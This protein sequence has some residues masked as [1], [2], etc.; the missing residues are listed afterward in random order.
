[1]KEN[2]ETEFK[3]KWG[4]RQY[5][6]LTSDQSQNDLISQSEF[7]NKTSTTKVGENA[8]VRME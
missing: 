7:K 1:M 4:K 6:K 8:W 2:K 5:P 3:P